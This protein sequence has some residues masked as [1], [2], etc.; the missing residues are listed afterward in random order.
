[1]FVHTVVVFHAIPWIL[2][3]ARFPTGMSIKTANKLG[4]SFF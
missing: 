4:K 2:D 3:M 1:M